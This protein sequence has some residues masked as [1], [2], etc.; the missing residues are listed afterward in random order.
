MIT[1][2]FNHGIEQIDSNEKITDIKLQLTHVNALPSRTEQGIFL[3][4]EL[5]NLVEDV[6]YSLV[7]LLG[8][9][10]PSYAILHS[11]GYNISEQVRRSEGTV[12]IDHLAMELKHFLEQIPL[13]TKLTYSFQLGFLIHFPI[14]QN[15]LYHAEIL[16][17]SDRFNCP[18]LLHRD[19]IRLFQRSIEHNLENYQINT[20]ICVQE[21]VAA[22]ISVAFEYPNTLISL[23]FKH[24]FQLSFVENT[25]SLRSKN[26]HQHA[27]VRGLYRTILSFNIQNLQSQQA[28]AL[29]QT[30][31]TSVDRYVLQNLSVNYFDVLTCDSCLLEII[32]ILILE[33][34]LHEQFL[35]YDSWSKSR[36]NCPGSLCL[37]F[38]TYLLQGKYAE[39][40]PYLSALGLKGLEKGTLIIIEY[41]CHVII[42]RSTQILSCLIVCLSER[43]N[44]ENITIAIDSYLYRSCPTYQIYMHN[45]IEHLCKR[46]I[47]MFH[48]VNSTNVSYVII[49]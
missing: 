12:L 16:S 39:L 43:Y 15:N 18:D 32:R 26:H 40:Q 34:C 10:I 27:Q 14:K 8:K 1:S 17:W 33:L 25:E 5:G 44:E 31:L 47:T 2:T 29:F 24:T 11:K 23:I 37:N 22:L 21:S 7:S 6:R 9:Q 42:R 30:L 3:I 35:S 38:L 48:F 36:L 46:W 20:I 45:E 49:R 41:I 13:N 4:I 19:F 28:R